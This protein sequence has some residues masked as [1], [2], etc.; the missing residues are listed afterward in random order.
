MS[1]RVRLQ[2]S[3]AAGGALMLR[4]HK[5]TTTI[6]QSQYF[7]LVLTPVHHSIRWEPVG[8]NVLTTSARCEY[9]RGRAAAA[10]GWLDAAEARDS[11]SEWE[12]CTASFTSLSSASSMPSDRQSQQ[13]WCLENFSGRRHFL[14]PGRSRAAA[15]SSHQ[16]T[17][18]QRQSAHHLTPCL[19]ICCYSAA[20]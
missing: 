19:H 1:I 8:L 4:P 12:F 11:R 9:A 13:S 3:Q 10:A 14:Q 15:S 17:T 6:T 20:N 18:T 2:K 16:I 7:Q 5:A